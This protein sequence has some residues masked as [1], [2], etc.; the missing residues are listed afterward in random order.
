MAL[1]FYALLCPSLASTL[2]HAT[3]E[4]SNP[5]NSLNLRGEAYGMPAF[6]AQSGHTHTPSKQ[7]R[8]KGHPVGDLYNLARPA[9]LEP[10][11]F[12]LGIR[13]SIRMSYG[14]VMRYFTERN[15]QGLTTMANQAPS[16]L[17]ASLEMLSSPYS[18]LL[19]TSP[20]PRDRTRSRMPSSA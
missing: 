1:P 20:S 2:P 14:R 12:G 6:P 19:Y 8:K 15:A 10:A 4:N 5:A 7:V 9:G 17:T 18:C 3:D 11:T 16:G 13:R